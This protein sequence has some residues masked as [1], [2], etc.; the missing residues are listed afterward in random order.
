MHTLTL[1]FLLLLVSGDEKSVYKALDGDDATALERYDTRKV[2]KAIRAGRPV[3]KAK[4]GQFRL[5]VE[6]CISHGEDGAEDG[7]EL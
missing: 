6:R 2:I 4:T 7:N 5:E 1:A 3:S